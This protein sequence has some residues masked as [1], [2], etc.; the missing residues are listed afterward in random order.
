MIK[1]ITSSLVVGPS[2]AFQE[3]HPTHRQPRHRPVKSM[4]SITLSSP[5]LPQRVHPYH[6]SRF[7]HADECKPPVRSPQPR[8]GAVGRG[9]VLQR[10]GSEAVS[11]RPVEVQRPRLVSHVVADEVAVARCTR[12]KIG[13]SMCMVNLLLRQTLSH[14]KS[15]CLF[16]KKWV[17]F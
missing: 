14:V 17:R 3:F 16:Q 4:A 11:A 8:N 10:R 9:P 13:G 5:R 15:E 7:I 12:R 1:T 2:I 6:V